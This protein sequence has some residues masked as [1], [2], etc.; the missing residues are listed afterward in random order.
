MTDE[1]RISRFE[2]EF[3][4]GRERFTFTGQGEMGG[5]AHGLARMGETLGNRVRP[6]FEPAMLAAGDWD[7]VEARARACLAAVSAG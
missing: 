6:L 3:F 5:K 1:F 2:R 7:A 4:S